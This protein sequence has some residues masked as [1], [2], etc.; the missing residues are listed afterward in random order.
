MIAVRWEEIECSMTIL[1]RLFDSFSVFYFFLS[2]L[3]ARYFDKI[4]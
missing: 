1:D 4:T 2:I 3:T